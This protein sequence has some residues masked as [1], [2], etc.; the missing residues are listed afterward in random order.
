MSTDVR[1]LCEGKALEAKRMRRCV[2]DRCMLCQQPQSLPSAYSARNSLL[3]LYSWVET[4]PSCLKRDQGCVRKR[5]SC[6][7]RDQGC[8]RKR[9]LRSHSS[10]RVMPRGC[11]RSLAT[12]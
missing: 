11:V 5:P 9:P 1:R 4:G 12:L 8:V 7:K 6:L 2:A 10:M 3:F